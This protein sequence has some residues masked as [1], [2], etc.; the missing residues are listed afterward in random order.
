MTILGQFWLYKWSTRENIIR[1][2][3]LTHKENTM[4]LFWNRLKFLSFHV[5]NKKN[6]FL[7]LILTIFCWFWQRLIWRVLC[8]MNFTAIEWYIYPKYIFFNFGNCSFQLMNL[9]NTSIRRQQLGEQS[10]CWLIC[11]L[12]DNLRWIILFHENCS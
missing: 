1:L 3:L 2:I 6:Y 5:L 4:F 11:H 7:F 10:I 9:L 8:L 12:D